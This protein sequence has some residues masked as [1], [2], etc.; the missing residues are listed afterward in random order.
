MYKILA[1][2]YLWCAYCV[3][4][5]IDN[6]FVVAIHGEI[7][8][9]DHEPLQDGLGLEGDDTIDI[10]LVF[11]SDNSAICHTG[12]IWEETLRWCGAQLFY[13]HWKV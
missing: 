12:D 1:N 8:E 6:Q 3:G 9:P 10:S 4:A 5:V 13:G 11:R 2:F 7:L